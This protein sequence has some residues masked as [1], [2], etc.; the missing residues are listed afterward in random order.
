ML[1]YNDNQNVTFSFGYNL[2][3]IITFKTYRSIN[4]SQKTLDSL[5]NSY[6]KIT[7]V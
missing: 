5:T 7:F 2:Y 3:V 4:V 6:Q 1:G